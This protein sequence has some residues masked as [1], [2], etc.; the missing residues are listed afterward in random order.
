MRRSRRYE[1]FEY[2][3]FDEDEDDDDVDFDGEAV[4]E[5]QDMEEVAHAGAKVAEEVTVGATPPGSEPR[6]RG[7]GRGRGRGGA[8]GGPRDR[9][10]EQGSH[11]EDGA[12]GDGGVSAKSPDGILDT[13]K[14]LDLPL[15]TLGV[16]GETVVHEGSLGGGVLPLFG[17]SGVSPAIIRSP[18]RLFEG[19]TSKTP[20]A[21]PAGSPSDLEN[22]LGMLYSP[23]NGGRG[24]GGLDTNG[25]PGLSPLGRPSAGARDDGLVVVGVGAK[26]AVEAYLRASPRLDLLKGGIPVPGNTGEALPRLVDRDSIHEH[27][28]IPG[29]TCSV[30]LSLSRGVSLWP[31]GVDE[32]LVAVAPAASVT[33]QQ[34]PGADKDLIAMEE[35]TQMLE[36][37]S[38][39]NSPRTGIALLFLA[40]AYLHTGSVLGADKALFSLHK[41]VETMQAYARQQRVT[42]SA[43]TSKMFEYLR[44]AMLAAKGRAQRAEEAARAA[45]AAAGAANVGPSIAARRKSELEPH[46]GSV[47][48]K[49]AD[50]QEGAVEEAPASAGKEGKGG[51]SPEGAAPGVSV[52]AGAKGGRGVAGAGHGAAHA[53]GLANGA[54]PNGILQVSK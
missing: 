1:D 35:K 32:A 22:V 11:P 21:M 36:R 29:C 39:P 51:G 10:R 34:V 15:P 31:C 3:D 49:E 27:A 24:L 33:A 5:D 17:S 16:D 50:G 48:P 23:A 54:L 2:G 46:L 43:Q 47:G 44:S 53:G 52:A 6:A 14:V 30:V 38:G 42:P 40:R 9:D 25:R 13:P 8:R 41:A 26:R 19:F 37:T 45:A 7:R 28:W 12:D 20:R 4:E 18:M